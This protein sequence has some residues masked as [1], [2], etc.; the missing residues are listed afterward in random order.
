MGNTCTPPA[1]P[2]RAFA[3]AGPVSLPSRPSPVH[4]P[5]PAPPHCPLL[6]PHTECLFSSRSP[7]LPAARPQAKI[8]SR[9]FGIL[10]LKFLDDKLGYACG[11]SG[12]LYKTG[13]WEGGVRE[14]S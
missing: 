2:C 11:G 6:N 5:H 7:P 13:E 1:N 9:G 4:C 14:G 10:D 3:T 12:S 8:G